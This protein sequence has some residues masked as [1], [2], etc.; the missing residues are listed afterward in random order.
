MKTHYDVVVVGCGV[1]GC[2]AALHLPK[3]TKIL[4]LSKGSL[5]ECDS[6]LAQGGICMLKSEADFAA[7]LEDTLKA[8]HYKNNIESV[9]IMINS[10]REVIKELIDYGVTFH[11]TNGKLDF[12][13][14]G[15][16][17]TNRILYHDDLTG[18]EITSVLQREVL[19]RDNITISTH[20]PMIDLLCQ[21]NNCYGVLVKKLE[22][23]VAILS[24][25]VILA[26]GGLGG[27]FAHSTNFPLL[28]GDGISLALKHD[29]KLK[30]IQYIQIHPTTLYS[31]ESG[32]RFLISESV[33][34]E[35]AI[36]LNKK[37]E[38]FVDELLPRDLV[39]KAI[40][41]QMK[42]DKTDHV[43]LSLKTIPINIKERFPN[44]VKRCL[45]EGYDPTKDFIPVVPAQHYL[46]GGIW[47]DTLGR[48]TMKHLFAAGETANN[49]VHGAN[50]LASNSLL[51]SLVF[52][53]RAT[54]YIR[55]NKELTLTT[56]E[57]KNMETVI[58]TTPGTTPLTTL[59]INEIKKELNSN[60]ANY[61]EFKY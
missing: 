15:A 52:A 47:T 29:V 26:C 5:E 19:K 39:A 43:W 44:I 60:E 9:K 32:K 3:T 40:Y 25:D 41:Q 35:G 50:R 13:R 53:K 30:D 51:E 42:K 20:T 6:Y 23:T 58:H 16:H 38:R 31:K 22:Q 45:E 10:S 2:F 57:N 36:L 56:L 14:E 18:K 48:T 7:Y 17:S 59:L 21:D 1:A 61:Y 34:G 4:M 49:G 8:G 46:M 55:E 24:Q 27:I 33:R 54:T 11:Q 12:T 37:G 28:T